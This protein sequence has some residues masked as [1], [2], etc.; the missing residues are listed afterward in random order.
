MRAGKLAHLRTY[1]VPIK[2]EL[3]NMPERLPSSP[4][5][6]HLYQVPVC[7]TNRAEIAWVERTS[8]EYNVSLQTWTPRSSLERSGLH[9]ADTASIR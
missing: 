5:L 3:V 7:I 9:I 1:S 8:P 6:Y 2:P 4:G